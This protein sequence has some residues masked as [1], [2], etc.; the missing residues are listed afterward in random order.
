MTDGFEKMILNDDNSPKHREV[1][2]TA[3]KTEYGDK[4]EMPSPE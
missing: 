2:H 4:R 1:V 3:A